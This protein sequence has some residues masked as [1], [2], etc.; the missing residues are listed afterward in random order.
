MSVALLATGALA[1]LAA[2]AVPLLIHLVRRPELRLLDFAALRWISARQR[3]QRRVTLEERGLLALRLL[4][5]ALL[6]LY[7]AQPVLRATPDPG[8]WVVVIPGADLAAARAALPPGDV[9]W[10]WLAPGFPPLDT[11]APPARD[12]ASLLRTLDAMLPAATTLA[13]VAPATLA[14]LDGERVRL[15][16]DIEWRIVPGGATVPARAAVPPPRLA[17]RHAGTRG[18]A[19]RYL[20]AVSEAWRAARPDV[21]AAQS[22]PAGDTDTL[23]WLHPGTVPPALHEWTA[24][25]RTLVIEPGT[26]LGD[27]LEHAAVVAWRDAAGT[28]LAT[29]AP[30]GSGRVLRLL[31]PLRPNT[32]PQLLEPGFPAM[33]QALLQPP[34]APTA[35]TAETQQP[36]RAAAASDGAVNAAAARPLQPWLA[37]LIAL[38]ALLERA[39][40]SRARR[41]AA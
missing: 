30:L 22:L 12:T 33:L 3:P 16:R 34:D 1:A 5:L 38:L 4:L 36:L 28:A 13:V 17:L 9:A 8:A 23:F 18:D 29:A 6:A 11:P 35:A 14:G 25:G 19:A 27:P 39:V 40:A 15:G 2:L 7:L 41:W 32:L 26:T 24:A 31:Q 21:A 37:V 20:H 10:R